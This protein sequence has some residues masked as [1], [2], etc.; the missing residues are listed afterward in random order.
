MSQNIFTI[1]HESTCDGFLFKL[2][3][4]LKCFKKNFMKAKN[5]LDA[6]IALLE[7]LRPAMREKRDSI[8]G[9]FI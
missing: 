5:S 6:S 1:S 3:C 9:V 7:T 2:I 8:T 4:R